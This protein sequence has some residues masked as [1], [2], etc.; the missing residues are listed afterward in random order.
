MNDPIQLSN[1]KKRTKESYFIQ[2]TNSFSR[3]SDLNLQE[4]MFYIYLRGY[5][6]ECFTNQSVICKEL[7]VSKPTLRKLMNSLEEKKYIHVQ[8]KYSSNNKEKASPIIRPIPVDDNTGKPSLDVKT[9]LEYLN[10]KYPSD[11]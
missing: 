2:V 9:L 6:D 11:Y 5:G 3:N 7:N 1:Y 10:K 8:R 4:K